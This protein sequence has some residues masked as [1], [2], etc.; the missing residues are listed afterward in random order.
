[1]ARLLKWILGIVGGLIV[2]VI[3]A[4]IIILSSYDFNDLKPVISKAVYDATGRELVIASDIDL[5]IGLSPSLVLSDIS[6]QNADWGTRKEMVKVGRFEIKVAL[7]PLLKK[8]I[9][10]NRFI[11]K[12]P[13]IL[14][15]TDKNGKANFEFKTAEKAPATES[16]PA[17]TEP[18]KGEIALPGLT[19][20]E[21]EI[22][23]GTLTYKDGKT[24]KAETVKLKNLKAGIQGLDKPFTIDLTGSYNDNQFD[25]S[26]T[27]GSINGINDPAI[28]WPVD[29]AVKAFGVNSS[30]KGSIKNPVEQ[31]GIKLDF[32]VK[33]GSWDKLSG[34]AGQE[35]PIK[36]ALSVSGNI[37]DPAPKSYQINSLK[38]LLGKNQIDGS[39]GMNLSGKVPF[40]DAS[41]SSQ[42]IDLKSLM[43]QDNASGKPVEK[44]EQA[45]PAKEN[46]RIFPD[47]PLPLDSLKLV[48]GKFKIRF[49]KVITP[50]M[51][52]NNLAIDSTMKNGTLSVKPLK[53]EM[54]GG[55]I[56]LEMGLASKGEAA[57]L[58][59]VINIKE[60]DLADMLAEAGS[61]YELEGK[62]NADIDI[63]GNG[64]SVAS[65]MAGLNGFSRIIM[66]EGKIDNKMI[67][68]LG[69]E[70]SKNV[71]RLLNPSIDQKQFT[72]IRCMV[73]RFDIRDGIAD[74]TAFALDTSMMSVVGEGN[75]NL[76]NEKLNLS[77]A[78]STKGGVA[79]YNLKLG[80]LSQ[81]FKLGGT[82]A[83]PSLVVDKEKTAVSI[84]K[85]LGKKLLKNKTGDQE[86]AA[87]SEV[88]VCAAA[89]E[90]AE[91]GVKMT[92]KTGPDVKEEPAQMTPQKLIEDVKKDPEKLL[93]D[94]A[95]DP[96]KALKGLKDLFKK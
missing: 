31:Q 1:M 38:V 65:I 63:K 47:D 4:V 42:E 34:L 78:P 53:A 45:P 95:K 27:L 20:N 36:D 61:K 68:K 39:I 48:D 19:V 54:G 25:M 6:F 55:S 57:D 77:L 86:T 88:D 21:F 24:G 32:S 84:G 14:I 79:G 83:K 12:D 40:I 91:T 46:E 75:V 29:I 96:K 87:P 67:D 33:I 15:E 90:A 64:N 50:Q 17:V 41:L 73:T 49:G 59:S 11:I 80:E 18:A 2:L 52:V 58:G 30:I 23:N 10:I 82:L 81:P 37:S 70:T 51:V 94:V 35:I 5:D 28:E 13:D 89:L 9:E 26:G 76:K 85:L 92:T 66:S 7:L 93:E 16:K 60:L 44:T 72:A 22:I 71:I 74:T 8:N 43:P 69:G 56:S 62:I 3:A